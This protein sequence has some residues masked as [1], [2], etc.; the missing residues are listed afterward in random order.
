MALTNAFYEAVQSGNVRRV[1][2]MMQDSLLVDPTF[3]EFNAMEKAASSMVGLYDEHDGKDLIEDRNMW[4][5]DYM[6]KVMVKVLSNFSHE[7]VDHLKEVVR[8]LRPVAKTI[9]P[10]KEQT[11]NQTCTT[12][13]K[14]SYE[15][16][17]RRCQECGDYLGAKIGAGA[18]VGAA[19]G[20]VIASVAGASVAGVIGGVVAGAV[21]GGVTTTLI[22][23]EGKR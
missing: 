17:K 5:D 2:I 14:G 3:T 19:V 18:A 7:R 16:E 6:D 20:G 9:A 4:N 13:K 11:S 10:K 8:Y 1:R 15:E 21:V 12:T 23:N 22:V